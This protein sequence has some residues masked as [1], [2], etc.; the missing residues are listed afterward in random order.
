MYVDGLFFAEMLVVE[1]KFMNWLSGKKRPTT[2]YVQILHTLF[3]EFLN[4]SCTIGFRYSIQ[5]DARVPFIL[6]PFKQGTGST[7][8]S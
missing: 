1:C 8:D 7:R 6:I 5:T 3:T 2:S 4:R